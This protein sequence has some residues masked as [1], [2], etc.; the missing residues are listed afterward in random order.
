MKIIGMGAFILFIT[1]AFLAFK[2]FSL[3]ELRCGTRLVHKGDTKAEVIHK[4]GEPDYVESW[5]EER[6]KRDFY[7]GVFL[8][9]VWEYDRYREPFLVK[10]LVKIEEWTYNFGSTRFIRYLRFENGILKDISIGGY[11][12]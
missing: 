4:C 1:F 9:R 8:E 2:D 7:T 5:E 6:I 3:A 10:E 11:G 12:Y